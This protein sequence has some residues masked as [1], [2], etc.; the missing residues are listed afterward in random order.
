MSKN[1]D[2]S[3]TLVGMSIFRAGE[4][5]N[6]RGQNTEW[7]LSDLHAMASNFEL[8]RPTFPNVPVRRDHVRSV[9]NVIG[10]FDRVYVAGDN[11]YGD[12]R[13][14]E[15]DAVDK[16]ER[17]TFRSSSIEVGPYESNKGDVTFP[18]VLGLAMVDIP[19][20][21]G[22]FQ[23]HDPKEGPVPDFTEEELDWAVASVYAQ[24]LEDQ[25]SQTESYTKDLDWAVAAGFAEADIAVRAELADKDKAPFLFQMGGGDTSSDFAS[26]QRRLDALNTYV[27]DVTSK[28]RVDFVDALVN[29]EKIGAPQR[30]DLVVFAESLTTEQFTAFRATYEGAPKLGVLGAKLDDGGKGPD[31]KSPLAEEYATAQEVVAHHQ[32]SGMGEDEVQKTDSYKRMIAL[33]EQ[34]DKENA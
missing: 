14:T 17:G 33:Q 18:A 7:K 12:F 5:R 3:A 28:I 25:T 24:A 16:F 22:L 1:D 4:F 21:E 31:P 11:L 23:R 15:P 8:L 34:L 9:D 20:V 13:I 6:S 2:G 32:R 19:A 29:D 30:D 26:V 27:N 10:Y